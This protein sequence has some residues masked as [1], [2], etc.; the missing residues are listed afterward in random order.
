VIH[1]VDMTPLEEA[2]QSTEASACDTG[3][4]Q[5][6]ILGT[7]VAEVVQRISG[8]AIEASAHPRPV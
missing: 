7:G 5:A 3:Q 6:T 8:L 1:P 4:S 2:N